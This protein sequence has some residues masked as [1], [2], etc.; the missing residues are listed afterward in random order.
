MDRRLTGWR[1]GCPGQCDRRRLRQHP[2]LGSAPL[3]PSPST[4]G[5][6]VWKWQPSE[7]PDGQSSGSTRLGAMVPA[8]LSG[9][10]QILFASQVQALPHVHEGKL[11]VLAVLSAERQPTLPMCLSSWRLATSDGL[12]AGTA[13]GRR[14]AARRSR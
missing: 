14:S 3:P 2:Q 8:L 11:C 5:V 4:E 12:E 7:I 6:E 13:P 10:I 1:A 9:P